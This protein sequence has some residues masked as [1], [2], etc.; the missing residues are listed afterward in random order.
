MHSGSRFG[1]AALISITAALAIP[2]TGCGDEQVKRAKEYLGVRDFGTAST[3]LRVVLRK[4]PAHA[5][6]AS[7]LL[8]AR[9]LEEGQTGIFRYQS[10][11]LIGGAIILVAVLA[12][13]ALSLRAQG[14]RAPVQT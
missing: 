4:K 2:L 10:I 6:A 13:G 8:Y 5:E 9:T 1:R 11:C 7:L 14:R 3:E 12:H